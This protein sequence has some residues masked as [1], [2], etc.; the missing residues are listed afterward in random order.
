VG[1]KGPTYLRLEKKIFLILILRF[2]CA[3][4]PPKR[5]FELF[6]FILFLTGRDN[7]K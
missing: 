4:T 5:F 1:K 3:R 7:H 2:F 6:I